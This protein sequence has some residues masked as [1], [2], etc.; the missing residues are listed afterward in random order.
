MNST[1]LFIIFF[2]VFGVVLNW[3]GIR[4]RKWVQGSSDFIVAG[5]E[6]SLLVNILGITSIGYAG[7]TLALSPA[8]ALMGGA[9]KAFFMLGFCYAIVG[10]GS[11][12]LVVAPLAR[13]SGAHTLPEWME[14]RFDK[15]VRVIIALTAIMAMLGITANNVVSMAHIIVG[16]TNWNLLLVTVI[17]FALFVGFMFASGMWGVAITDVL[18]GILCVVAMPLL[19]IVL[20]IKYGGVSFLNN[21]WPVGSWILNGITGKTFPFFSL[22]YPSVLVALFLYGLALTWGS[23]HYWIRAS[24][25][26]SERVAKNSFLWSSL[27]L[28]LANGVVYVLVG[29]YAGA[30]H[31][32]AFEPIGKTPLTGAFGVLLKDFNPVIAAYLMVTTIAAS[33]STAT[34]TY[35]AGSSMVFRDI[36]QRFFR[37]KAKSSELVT[38]SRII[39][40][41][42]GLASLVLCFYPKGPVYLFA[43]GTAWLIPSA[44]V[45]MLGMFWKRCT[46]TGAFV[47]GLSGM[48]LL[49]IWT[50]LDLTKIYPMTAKFGHMVI[51]GLVVTLVVSIIVSLFTQEKREVLAEKIKLEDMD[52]NTLVAISKGY[53]TMSEITDLLNVDSG[54]S[55]SV[56]NKLE[57]HGLITRQGSTYLRYYTFN[58]TESGK[59]YLPPLSQKD[60]TLLADNLDMDSLKILSYVSNHPNIVVNDLLNIV[61]KDAMAVSTIISSLIRRGL[62]LEGGLTRRTIKISSKGREILSKYQSLLEEA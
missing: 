16:F 58:I 54:I 55:T 20:L 12:G 26:R 46:S 41:L 40:L 56:I 62:L 28:V 18:Q 33:I 60:K 48:L 39:T 23:N 29:S 15:R 2:V 42:F 10:I 52:I 59:K 14:T 4:A 21:N 1:L 7:T 53:N 34:G 17:A 24:S 36:Y 9:L 27:L 38:P 37:P 5:R 35:I 13:R 6:V 31:P 8:F 51:P 30:A 45:L 47:G 32:T 3:L 22:H 44:I 61:H 50:I 49:T 25:V 19:V 43:F 57:S 11:Y